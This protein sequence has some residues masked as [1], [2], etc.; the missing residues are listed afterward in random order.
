MQSGI[1]LTAKAGVKIGNLGSLNFSI[2]VTAD[3]GGSSGS[4]T[5]NIS[6]TSGGQTVKSRNININN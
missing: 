6:P 5:A 1:L 4:I 2:Q 3:N